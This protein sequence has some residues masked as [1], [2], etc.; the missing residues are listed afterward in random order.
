M[1]FFVMAR[2]A[3]FF[4]GVLLLYKGIQ[5]AYSKAHQQDRGYI[6]EIDKNVVSFPDNLL[7]F[8]EQRK[9]Y[10]QNCKETA[11]GVQQNN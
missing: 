3:I 9:I 6:F 10:K 7:R 1:R 8:Y 11:H 2:I 4:D 5:S